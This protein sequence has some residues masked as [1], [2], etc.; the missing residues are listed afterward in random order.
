MVEM[1]MAKHNPLHPG[2]KETALHRIRQL[3]Y[4]AMGPTKDAHDA[5][6]ADAIRMIYNIALN[7]CQRYSHV[8]DDDHHLR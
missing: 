8:Q 3:A 4:A 6:F 2:M 1:Y 5:E 7:T